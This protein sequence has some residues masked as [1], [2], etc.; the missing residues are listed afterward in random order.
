MR[1]QFP[2]HWFPDRTSSSCHSARPHVLAV[3]LNDMVSPQQ[4]SLKGAEFPGQYT[5]GHL[6]RGFMSTPGRGGAITAGVA[7]EM[8]R[9]QH[10]HSRFRAQ[11]IQPWW[12]AVCRWSQGARLSDVSQSLCDWLLKPF[13]AGHSHHSTTVQAPVFTQVGAER[14]ARLAP[15]P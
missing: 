7:H 14:P 8:A 2:F 6:P 1:L 11:G 15:G 4:L 12:L 9:A 13:L 3:T 5:P 10:A